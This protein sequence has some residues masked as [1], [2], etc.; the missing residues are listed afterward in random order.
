VSLQPATADHEIFREQ[1]A[2]GDDMGMWEPSPWKPNSE[3]KAKKL[4]YAEVRVGDVSFL[5]NDGLQYCS[6]FSMLCGT[7]KKTEILSSGFQIN[8]QGFNLFQSFVRPDLLAG[9]SLNETFIPLGNCDSLSRPF[10]H[11]D[12]PNDFQQASF[13]YP[14]GYDMQYYHVKSSCEGL[15]WRVDGETYRS[16]V[17]ADGRNVSLFEPKH[18]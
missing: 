7:Q 8:C 15:S 11:Y 10:Y 1:L 14:G 13:R 4:T 5:S 17:H 16:L 9:W 18:T 6:I 12:S 3:K 2:I